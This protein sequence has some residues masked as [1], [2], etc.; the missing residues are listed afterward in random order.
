MGLSGCGWVV[1]L[2]RGKET[3]AL[4]L[5]VVV[6]PPSAKF[7]FSVL[8]RLRI[9]RKEALALPAPVLHRR[10]PSEKGR[11]FASLS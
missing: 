3:L 5:C 8:V 2:A 9:V 6:T 4:P 10:A 7:S 11:F 1:A